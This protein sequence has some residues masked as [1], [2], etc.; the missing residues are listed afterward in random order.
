MKTWSILWLP[1]TLALLL[2]AYPPLDGY[3]SKV[4]LYLGRWTGLLTADSPAA[5]AGLVRPGER[6]ITVSKD[7]SFLVVSVRTVGA[8]QTDHYRLDGT[9]STSGTGRNA[10]V[11][12]LTA[13]DQQLL[14]KRTRGGRTESSSLSI[15]NGQLIFTTTLELPNARTQDVVITMVR[16]E[17]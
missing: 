10:V 6:T 12:K 11:L 14:L 4:D 8:H 1:M 15:S 13:T 9:D 5:I 16:T 3:Q 2:V 7:D 17:R